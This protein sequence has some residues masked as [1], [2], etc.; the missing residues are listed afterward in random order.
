[1]GWMSWELFRQPGDITEQLYMAQADA[2]VAGGYIDA[3]YTG[4]HIDD[5]WSEKSRDPKSGALRPN[6][7]R[8]P[9]GMANL[10][11]YI[12]QRGGQFGLYTAESKET[13]AGYPGS[14]D[15]EIV[16]AN[17][18]RDWGVDYLKVDGCGDPQYYAEG[19]KKMG[20][21]LEASGRDIVYS[22]SWPAY[23]NHGNESIQPFPTFINDGCNLWRNWKDIQCNWES[24]QSIMDHW[25][26]Y[27]E[28]LA[29]FAAPGH[30]HDPDM[31]L[32]GANCISDVEEMTQMA[33]WC[34]SAA[35]LIMGNDLRNVSDAS[36]N[37]LLNPD[38]IAVNQDPLGQMGTRIRSGARQ[39]WARNLFNGDI[40]VAAH[41]RAAAQ[42]DTT[43]PAETSDI[44]IDFS[45][46]NLFGEIEVYDIW[47]RL[48]VGNFHDNYT[49]VAI[50]N[51]GT[52]FLRLRVV[53]KQ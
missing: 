12:H 51:H 31:L 46:L 2:L 14:K 3:G 13:C 43:T 21:A 15:F 47:K 22:C 25:G 5:C 27:G 35:P 17:T 41:Y 39:L 9:H 19:Y 52:A 36:R 24:L 10:G 26:E 32:I 23:M 44:T 53:R 30:W 6:A 4:V 37:I 11:D 48:V 33:I 28:A 34:I 49:A 29:P 8:F 45:L 38:A 42:N 1:M 18:F 20:A 50:P 7:S 40:A 16:D